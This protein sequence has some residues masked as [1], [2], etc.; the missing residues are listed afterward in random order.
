MLRI[1]MLTSGGDCQALNAAMRGVVKGI[2]S[3]RSDVEIYGFKDGYKGLIYADRPKLVMGGELVGWEEGPALSPFCDRWSEYRKLFSNF[4]GN[5]SKV[6]A[7]NH[8]LHDEVHLFLKRILE[9]PNEWVE[10]TRQY[11]R[12]L[13]LS[14]C[15][16][17]LTHRQICGRYRPHACLWRQVD[18]PRRRRSYQ[19]CR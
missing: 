2:C 4:M 17:E 13:I 10:H 8:V 19:G 18:R 5:R 15:R 1:G 6:E 9:K 14:S 16:G 3:K 12:C 11:V 7:Y